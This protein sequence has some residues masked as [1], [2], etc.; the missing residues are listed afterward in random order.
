MRLGLGLPKGIFQYADEIG[1]DVIVRALEGLREKTG[2]EEYEP[3]PLLRRMVEEGRLGVK[4]GKGFYE[5]G[6]VEERKMKNIVVR[7]QP[8]I[9]WVVLNR[10]EKLNAIS[11][12]PLKELIRALDELEEDERVRV[13]VLTGKGRAFSAGVDVQSFIGITPVKAMIYSRKFQEVLFKIEYYTKPVIA[14]LNGFTLGGGLEL[15]MAADF[16]IASETAMLGQP[17]I[18]LASYPALAAR[19]GSPGS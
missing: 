8:P 1:I 16:R 7:V 11:V 6:E 5:Y 17:E 3:D 2:W 19:R 13:V 10:P 9:A 15:A 4:T 14:A 18:N 12:E